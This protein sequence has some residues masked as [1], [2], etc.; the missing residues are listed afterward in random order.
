MILGMLAP[1]TTEN[2]VSEAPKLVVQ[3]DF[4]K[5]TGRL[6]EFI[7]YL[8]D[9]LLGWF[10]LS[11]DSQIVSTIYVLVI[12][13]VAI[14]I[15]WVVKCVVEFLCAIVLR[16]THNDI[17]SNLYHTR[18][19]P[20]LCNLVAPIMFLIMMQLT[21]NTMHSVAIW[22][23][24]VTLIYITILV[25]MAVCRLVEAVWT[26]VNIQQ[27]TRRLPLRGIVQLVKGIV[28]II[29]IIIAVSILVDKSPA[30]LLAGLG[31]FAAVLMLVFKDSILGVV[32]GVQLS[33]NDALHVGD[34][35]K[36]PGTD[37]NGIVQEV[38]LTSI[39]VQ[40]FDKTTTTLPPYSLVSGSFT[41]YRTMSDSNTR[42][43]QR[44]WM[45]DADSIVPLD[46][47]LRKQ[48]SALPL[49]ADYFNGDST[50][51]TPADTNLGAFRAYIEKYLAANK[52]ISANDTT[53]VTTLAQ[54]ANG[55][56][57]QLYCFTN[58]SSWVDYE[59]IQASVFEHV[60]I[61]MGR[62]NL[63]T[64]EGASGRDTI[65]EGYVGNRTDGIVGIPYPFF[66]G[67]NTPDNP[68]QPPK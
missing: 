35:I 20:K 36:V 59:H 68:G 45:I 15:G 17:Y 64:F 54:T 63:Y 33:G 57:L 28:L 46:D 47:V 55:V 3:G 32:A 22:F 42:R 10:N 26:H 52:F 51:A 34:W 19:F 56:P 9:K 24:R 12:M 2:V 23:E 1:G 16:H 27:N 67:S 13:A 41:N 30:S 62:F 8:V 65:L 38:T 11:D 50:P 61:M 31:A 48:I 37:A 49:M 53:F 5:D 29:V 66:Q 39:K 60:A 43:I 4:V 7:L 40:N 25:G 14:G 6:A 21:L 18:F 58:T 44:A